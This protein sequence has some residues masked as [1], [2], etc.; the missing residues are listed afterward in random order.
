MTEAF[1][2]LVEK[3]IVLEKVLYD[4]LTIL[5]QKHSEDIWYILYSK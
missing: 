1:K 3:F 2:A 4:N 5:P